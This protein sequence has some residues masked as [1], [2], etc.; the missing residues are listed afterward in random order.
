MAVFGG[1][2]LTNKGL[3]L[4]G[5]AQ[6]GGKLNYTRIA[7]GDGSLTGQAVPAMNGLISPKISLP[8]TR[9]T[10][11]PPNKAIIGSVLRNADVSTGFYW[12]EVG[13]F[14]QDPDAGEILYAYANAGVTADYIP[15]GGGSDIIEKTFDCV[16]AVG[17]AANITAVIDESL[18]F[19]KK[20]ELDTVDAAKVDKV[21]GK[22]LSANDY[23]TAEKSKLAG[24]TAGAGGAGSATDTVIGSRTISDTTAPT[25]DSGT[26][27]NLLGW[28]AN[29]VKSITGKSSWRTAP[30]TTLEA[31]KAHADDTTRH[32]TAAERTAWNAKETP[33]GAQ[34]KA[35][36]VKAAA[37]TDATTKANA[38]QAA[39]ATD[40]T[41]KA[42]AVQ[43]NLNSHTGNTTLHLTASERDT[44][45]AKA[46]KADIPSSLPA[47][48][49]N[50][51]TVDGMHA[52]IGN[53]ANSIVARDANQDITVRRFISNAATGTAPFVVSSTTAV[54]NLNTDMVDGYHINL[55]AAGSTIAVRD[56]NGDITSRRFVSN[57]VTG[58]SPFLVTSTTLNTNLNADLL[59]GYQ[60]TSFLKTQAFSGTDFNEMT[61]SG[62]FRLGA[63]MSNS[64]IMQGKPSTDYGQMFVMAAGGD[65]IFQLASHYSTS[66]LVF[67]VGNPPQ[68]GGSG[69]YQEWNEI[70]TS[71]NITKSTS[72]PSGGSDGDIWLQYS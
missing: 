11:Q 71:K 37:A 63:N 27:T 12:R 20:T 59:D 39:A 64:P 43:S 45:N 24:I 1:M 32:L 26:V 56:G 47:S 5:K 65:T 2:T 69:S 19:A 53:A 52:S 34:A 35:D 30:A 38:A 29:T 61:T 51:D 57:M 50:A 36:A 4:Q 31:A 41:T 25:G 13:V 8:I 42:N 48:G 44:W 16:V 70:Y 10:T 23:T 46:N 55:G 62:L 22:G 58:T 15:P 66:R 49:G 9:I 21:S 33:A 40:A 18:V 72:A 7:V 60:A 17:T 67:R 28:L 6:A 14:A 68:L 3:V 54:A